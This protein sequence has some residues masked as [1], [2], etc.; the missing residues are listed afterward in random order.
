MADILSMGELLIDF[1]PS[2]TGPDGQMLFARNPGG[3]PANVAVQARC[4]GVSAGFLGCVGDDMFGRFLFDTL[5]ECS[6]TVR[7]QA[8]ENKR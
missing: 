6:C 1:T 2:G 5:K 4:V 8:T 7:K 3:A